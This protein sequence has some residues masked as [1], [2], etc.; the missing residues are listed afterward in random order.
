MQFARGGWLVPHADEDMRRIVEGWFGHADA[1]LLG[2][3]TP[4]RTTVS[5]MVVKV[6]LNQGSWAAA[7]AGTS[8]WVKWPNLSSRWMS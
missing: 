3:T 8:M 4:R 7:S 6:W 2:R 5:F 1:I